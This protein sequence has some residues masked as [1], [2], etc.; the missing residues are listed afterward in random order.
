MTAPRTFVL[1]LGGLLLGYAFLDKGFA[2]VGVHP[3]YVGEMVLLVGLVAFVLG[4]GTAHILHSPITIAILGY[5]AWGAV[6]TIPEIQPYGFEAIRNSAIWFYSIFALLTA[7]VL[8]RTGIIEKPIDWFGRWFPWFL[9]WAPIGYL[10]WQFYSSALPTMPGTYVSVL[11]LKGGDL[12]VHLTGVAA[13]LALGL[14]RRF[15]AKVRP[16]SGL[17]EYL[18][19]GMVAFGVLVTGSRVRASLVAFLGGM[20][21]VT[22]FRPSNRAI[23]LVV[24]ALIVFVALATFDFSIADEG[25]KSTSVEQLYLNIQSIV[26]PH[27]HARLAGTT[28]WRLNWWSQIIDYTV[29]GDYFWT[30]KGYGVNLSLTDGFYVGS[31]NRS[32]HNGTMTILARSGVPGLVF[33]LLLQ[34]A[35]FHALVSRYFAARSAGYYLL[36]DVNLWLAAYWFAFVLNSCFDVYLEGPQGGIWFWCLVGFIIAITLW[37]DTVLRPLGR[38]ASLPVTPTVEYSQRR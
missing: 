15:P 21:L 11:T 31:T 16:P 30:G 34:G 13:F 19:W 6:A 33:W 17:T 26:S 2:Y 37:Q 14:H 20:F 9:I 23:K 29:F 25:P 12:G 18:Y 27:S 24:A 35:I 36:A 4:G 5:A 3:F 8:L 10:A 7:A 22:L 38:G 32:P 1:L 28:E